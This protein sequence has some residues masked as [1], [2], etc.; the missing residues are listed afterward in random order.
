MLQDYLACG[1][2]ST[3]SIDFFALNAYEWCGNNNFQS[4]GYESLTANLTNFNI[5]IFFSE[6][7]L[8][9]C[10]TTDIRGPSSHLWGP[11][12]PVLVRRHHLRVDP[13]GQ[14]LR[15]R[16]LRSEGRSQLARRAARWLPSLRHTDPYLSGLQQSEQPVEDS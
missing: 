12:E 6:G 8:H 1:T 2:N 4:S 16:E 13:R 15:S 11:D 10:A 5:P 7:R 9:H 3:E 14:P